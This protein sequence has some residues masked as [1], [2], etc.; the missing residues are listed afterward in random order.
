V[1]A[2][3]TLQS[4]ISSALQQKLEHPL[5]NIIKICEEFE[6]SEQL[7]SFE[8]MHGKN[9]S[10]MIN[11]A[12]LVSKMMI[13]HL[14][15]MHDWT[16]LKSG[17]FRTVSASFNLS[18]SLQ[19]LYDMMVLRADMKQ[20]RLDIIVSDSLPERVIG[21]RSRMEQVAMNLI[22]NAISHTD[23]GYVKVFVDY[24]NR[25]ERI[26]FEVKDTGK[27]IKPQDKKSVFKILKDEGSISVG[28]TL[29]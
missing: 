19:S 26:K 18:E 29:C 9:L 21:D 3:N 1:K 22:S 15:D 12:R 4:A 16:T 13:Y 6:C 23:R 2:Q 10:L 8:K 20:L 17:D 14:K 11:T 24:N 25:T 28:L 27:G 5:S 7:K